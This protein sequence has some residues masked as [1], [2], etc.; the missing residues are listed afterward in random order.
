MIEQVYHGT[1]RV[2]A[3]NIVSKSNYIDR[4]KGGGELGMGFYVG[5]SVA[6]AAAFAKAKFNVS[7]EVIEFDMKKSE[8]I[9]LDIHLVK[10]REKVYLMWKKIITLKKRLLYQFNKDVVVAPFAT[11][12]ICMQYKFESERG[13]DFLNNCVKR[14]L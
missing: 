13:V 1:D 12:D 14:I 7:G 9:K 4:T 10:R 5:D 2:T 6:I 11:I 8:F 3:K